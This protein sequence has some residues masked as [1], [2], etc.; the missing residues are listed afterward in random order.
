MGVEELG[1]EWKANYFTVEQIAKKEK[2]SLGIGPFGSN[3][4]VA[5]YRNEGHPLV[6]VREIRA[7]QFGGAGTKYVDHNKFL[8]LAAHRAKPGN[9]LITKMGDPPGGDVAM[10]PDY[11]PESVITSDCIKLDINE[12]LVSKQYVF[13]YMQSDHFQL[14]MRAITAGVAQQKVNLKTSRLWL[15]NAFT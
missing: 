6:F 5:D 7:R 2:Y 12:E 9:I 1:I 15:V 8:E 4:K 10:Y 3:L 13:Y 14:Q 11:L